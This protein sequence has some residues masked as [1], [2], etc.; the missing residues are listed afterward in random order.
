MPVERGFEGEEMMK[1][2]IWGNP[3]NEEQSR[4]GRR[5]LRM[6]EIHGTLRGKTCGKYEE[7]DK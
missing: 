7:I 3:I 6:Q 5:Y 1:L 4:R 2:D